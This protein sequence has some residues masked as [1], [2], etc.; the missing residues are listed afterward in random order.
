MQTTTR[1]GFDTNLFA[2]NKC[3]GMDETRV[4]MRSN[5]KENFNANS[6]HLKATFVL[7]FALFWWTNKES[8]VAAFLELHSY[9]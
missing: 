8:M 4:A 5:G 1:L 7:N 9:I 6:S 2:S 3:H